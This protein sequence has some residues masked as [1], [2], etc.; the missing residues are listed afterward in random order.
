M[1]NIFVISLCTLNFPKTN[2]F[3]SHCFNDKMIQLYK[4]ILSLSKQSRL[5]R[6]P[7]NHS[8]GIRCEM[9]RQLHFKDVCF[10][11]KVLRCVN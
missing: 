3:L 4:L 7:V 11:H 1:S 5:R 8:L 10:L 6:L 9:G 2:V